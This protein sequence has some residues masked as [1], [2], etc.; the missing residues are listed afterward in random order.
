MKELWIETV[1]V[2]SKD[3]TVKLGRFKGLTPTIIAKSDIKVA[4]SL[5]LRTV[6]EREGDIILLK[7]PTANRIKKYKIEGK[8]ICVKL[9]VKN[10]ADE[11]EVYKAASQGV[12]YII[13]K[14]PNWKV[15]PLENLI[16][17]LGGK[18]KL[19][20]EVTDLKSARLAL[21][22]LELGVDGVVLKTSSAE[23]AVKVAS[24]MEELATK[25]D[26]PDKAKKLELT[27]AKVISC[28][29]LGLG[30]RVCVDTCD[31]MTAGEGIL[32]GCQSSGLFLVQAEVEI[33]PHVEPRPFRVNAGPVSLYIL[34]ADGKTKYLSELEAGGEVSIVDRGGEKR[35]AIV[36]RIK[37]ERRPLILVEAK[38]KGHKVKTILQN[39]ETIHLVTSKGSKSVRELEVGEEVLVY[40]QP[41]GRHFGELVK[42]ETV[43]ER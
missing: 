32:V 38:V 15:I 33:N 5:G 34:T 10:R 22:A 43:L 31:L 37:I 1:G 13:V 35:G 28:K 8:R 36:G 18:S 2:P 14:C 4:K 21:G 11:G 27:P 39:A 29:E 16:A 17:M 25:K 19:L 26:K 42:E 6:S 7:T 3:F 41:G 20:A 30:A 9:T 12:D 24:M 23:A 40:Y